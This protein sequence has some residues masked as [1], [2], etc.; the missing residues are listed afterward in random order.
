M[1]FDRPDTLEARAFGDLHLLYRIAK[2]VALGKP[3]PGTR[4]G[5]F[6]Q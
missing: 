3:R 5:I 4:H 1:V 6:H 2:N